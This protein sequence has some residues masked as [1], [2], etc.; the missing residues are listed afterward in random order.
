MLVYADDTVIYFSHRNK[1]AIEKALPQD[2][3][4]ISSWLID[5]E[6]LMNLKKG[7]TGSM[8]F[9]TSKR[10]SNL[11]NRTLQLSLRFNDINSTDVY[12]YLGVYLDP[13]L[14]L[15]INFEKVY[16]ETSSRVRMLAKVRPC[17]TSKS[18][19]QLYWSFV[20]PI[21]T[22]CG[23][24]N[25]FSCNSRRR[26]VRSLENRAKSIIAGNHQSEVKITSLESV[27][28]HKWCIFTFKLRTKELEVI[29]LR[30]VFLVYV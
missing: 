16:K 10:L 20:T 2:L 1:E 9:G 28:F 17:L 30:Y 24:V 27:D 5:N 19:L 14:N 7:K 4:L 21:L 13:S 8:L 25:S 26:V 29:I 3:S 6:L 15:S 18:A 11:S 23:L 12:K 22:Y